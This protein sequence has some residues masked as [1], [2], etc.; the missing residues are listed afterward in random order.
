MNRINKINQSI[1]AFSTSHPILA[2][3]PDLIPSI[4]AGEAG[5]IRSTLDEH[6]HPIKGELTVDSVNSAT[7]A[8]GLEFDYDETMGWTYIENY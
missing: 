3:V 1:A 8:H 4:H 7:K 6:Q 2:A 5:D